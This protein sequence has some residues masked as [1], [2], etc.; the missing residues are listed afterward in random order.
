MNKVPRYQLASG[1]SAATIH[2]MVCPACGQKRFVPYIDITTGQILSPEVGIC[3]RRDNCRYHL[4]PR[5]WFAA[6]GI[7][8]KP[9]FVSVPSMKP[10]EPGQISRERL[11][12][13]LIGENNLKR[14][15]CSI[16][17]R[18]EVQ[19]V[20]S[21][22]CV[23][24]TEYWR[25]GLIFWQIDRYGRIRTG[26]KMLYDISTG[27]RVKE[28]YSRISWVHCE[29]EYKGGFNLMQCLFGE[30]L[31]GIKEY[32]TKPVGIV[33]S[34]KTALIATL[35]Q[36]ALLWLATGGACNLNA[37]RCKPLIHKDVVLFPDEGKFEEWSAKAKELGI[38]RIRVSSL[39]EEYGT[40]GK[41]EDIADLFLRDMQR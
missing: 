19:R 30:H 9:E 22:Y 27:K 28:G 5:E 26:K 14:F 10:K 16:Y 15:L 35:E 31:L 2:K 34:E 37:E 33:E 13:S 1:A 23:G 3:D 25:G 32:A 21:M 36:P 29:P 18:D 38:S 12:N 11:I 17:P 7:K 40:K 8:P 6:K 39:M 24:N 20:F 4:P 41:G